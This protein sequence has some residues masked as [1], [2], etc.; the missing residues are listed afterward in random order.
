[1]SISESETEYLIN[2]YKSKLS[3]RQISKITKHSTHFISR[4]L[5]ENGIIIVKYNKPIKKQKE[6]HF[7]SKEIT[8]ELE[9][10]IINLY[11][12]GEK[13]KIISKK[14]QI[15][16]KDVNKIIY[17]KHNLIKK[18]QTPIKDYLREHKD[19]IINQYNELSLSKL[20][21]LYNVN[22][23]SIRQL[24]K[25]NNIELKKNVQRKYN[26]DIEFFKQESNELY[27]M[28]GFILADGNISQNINN[29]QFTLSICINQKDI[30]ILQQFCAWTGLN[31]SAIHD[32]RKNFKKIA[33]NNSNLL[34]DG[35]IFSKF[36]IIPNKTYNPIEP[37]IN[38]Q[39]IKPFILGLLDGDGH[40]KYDTSKPS[41]KINLV[42]STTII[43][44]YIK[45]LNEIGFN[46]K[47]TKISP[48]GK[49]WSRAN[50]QKKQDVL[51]LA[52][53]LEIDKY[54]FILDRKWKNLKQNL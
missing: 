54:S 9:N 17:K 18:R 1:M 21:E 42:C 22:E 40:I 48:E 39:Y 23:W 26:F 11:K 5:K 53:L 46:G 2:L 32:F 13:L 33:F 35:Y 3:I 45:V 6:R 44:W 27:Y 19:I 20:A 36:G 50:I 4:I 8:K 38:I 52:K 30:C 7:E 47:I 25:E 49:V 29:K 34:N 14:L 12:L 28:M 16:S 15:P 31:I 37:N 43:N 41:Y 24:L 10:K 51:N